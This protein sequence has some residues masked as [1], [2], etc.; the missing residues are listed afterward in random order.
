MVYGL[1]A[2]GCQRS[3]I[4][5]GLEIEF[6]SARTVAKFIIKSLLLLLSLNKVSSARLLLK[7]A[8]MLIGSTSARLG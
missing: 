2:N 6:L 1:V 5:A 4:Y 3:R 8:L 7:D